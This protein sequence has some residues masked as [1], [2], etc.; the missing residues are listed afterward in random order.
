MFTNG[1]SVVFSGTNENYKGM[2]IAWASLVEK[3]HLIV[4]LPKKSEA[5]QQ[6]LKNEKFSINILESSQEGIAKYFGGSHCIKS[7]TPDSGQLESTQYDLPILLN[8]CRSIIC[9]VVQVNEV[10]DNV[11]VIANVIDVI[12]DSDN[13]PLIFDLAVYFE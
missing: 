12:N 6:L 4:S 7:E 3:S 8:C 10:N 5:T 13:K 2:T 11:V 1:V 9:G